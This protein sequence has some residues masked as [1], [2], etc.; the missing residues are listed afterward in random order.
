MLTLRPRPA[1]VHM[2][3][4]E[5]CTTVARPESART[6]GRAPHRAIASGDLFAVAGL[7]VLCLALFGPHVLGSSTFVGNSDRLS[8]FLNMRLIAVDSWQSMGRVPAW[9]DAMLLGVPL[10]GLHW[11]CWP[12]SDSGACGA[13]SRPRYLPGSGVRLGLAPRRSGARG[14]P[15]APRHRARAV[16]GVRRRRPL[17][18]LGLRDPSGRTGRLGVRDVHLAADRRADPADRPTGTDCR[19]VPR[20][21]PRWSPQSL[22]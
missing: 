1:R 21:E 16:P 6:P 19:R 8:T 11:T 9:S 7:V 13:P 3:A 20:P 22:D 18:L 15:I 12:R 17:R 10:F 5:A 14:L 2:P 4:A